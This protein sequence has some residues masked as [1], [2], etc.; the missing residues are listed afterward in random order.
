MSHSSGGSEVKAWTLTGLAILAAI[1]F[2]LAIVQFIPVGSSLE[3]AVLDSGSLDGPTGPVA[4]KSASRGIHAVY[5]AGDVTIE[6]RPPFASFALASNESIDPV[7]PPG[8]FEAVV[9]AEVVAPGGQRTAR[10]GAEISGGTLEIRHKGEVITRGTAA[11][12]PVEVW[13]D[14]IGIP[15]NGVSLEFRFTREGDA[16][17]SFRPLWRPDDGL[18]AHPLP[19][20]DPA[21]LVRD[22]SL[23]GLVLAQNLNCASCHAPQSDSLR[24]VLDDSPAPMLGDVGARI[25]PGWLRMWL[26]NPHMFNP[27]T[28][29]P[30]VLTGDAEGKSELITDLQH[31][32]VSL[33]GPIVRDSQPANADIIATGMVTYHQIGCVSCHGPLESLE[34]LPGARPNVPEPTKEYAPLQQIMGKMPRSSLANFL[35]DPVKWH[36]AGR[37]PSLKMS[38]LEA[39]AVAAYLTD[40]FSMRMRPSDVELDPARV[41]RGKEAFVAVGCAS[42]HSL[43]DNHPIVRRPMSSVSFES[44][45]GASTDGCIAPAEAPRSNGQ[46]LY[47][48]SSRDRTALKAFLAEAARW[49]TDQSPARIASASLVRMDCL[50]CH[51]YGEAGGPERSVAAYFESL[52]D[53]DMGDE[54]RIPPSLSHIGSKLN[55]AWMRE[56]LENAGVARPYMAT[57]MPQFGSANVDHLPDSLRAT[58]GMTTVQ[59]DGPTQPDDFASIGRHLVG[60]GGFNCIQCHSI[61]G[62]AGV[63]V[64][65]PDLALAPERLRH[66]YFE[67]WLLEPA[68]IHPGTRMP[69]YFV[70]GMSPSSQLGGDP[71]RQVNAMWAYLSQGEALPLPDGLP[72]TGGFAI[73]VEDEPVVFRTFM[74][75]VGSRAI[76]V[77]YPEKIHTAFD[78]DKARLAMVWIGDF[79]N[80][81][82]AWG[83]RGGTVTDPQQEPVWVAPKGQPFIIAQSAPTP[84]PETVA[85]DAS[86]FHGYE[87]DEE[88]RPTFVYELRSPAGTVEVREKPIP[89]RSG[90]AQSLHRHFALKGPPGAMVWFNG[91]GMELVNASV[92]VGGIAGPREDGAMMIPLDP[93]GEATFEVKISW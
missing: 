1:V 15:V 22:R 61:A 12:E 32:L 26:T 38:D 50:A 31:Y 25:N 87:L 88:R 91:Q 80:A 93:N 44:L 8:P 33:G 58:A 90:D 52:D 47:S 29:M 27:E 14:P 55:S 66:E 3:P 40:K 64:P 20:T 21:W 71:D 28:P 78:A 49:M 42:C 7:L 63:N 77:G 2:S 75:E 13:S 6:R 70:A 68:V 60:I 84:W 89:G 16:A 30:Q 41:E 11:G 4:S 10:F 37:M 34:V 36:P 76:A 5:T 67:R 72:D 53:A 74:S 59:D 51:T 57:R 79:L 39:Q 48:L 24:A 43:G 92:E 46:V 73:N 35:K 82:G 18:A 65:G 17:T 69:S 54:G 9:T 45:A 19:A 85:N 56:V 81:Q 83:G 86:L 62:R 23:N